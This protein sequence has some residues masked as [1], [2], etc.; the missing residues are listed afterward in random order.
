MMQK[1]IFLQYLWGFAFIYAYIYKYF[2]LVL[3]AQMQQQQPTTPQVSLGKCRACGCMVSSIDSAPAK[4]THLGV[5][6]SHLGWL[7]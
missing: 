5:A 2:Y 4:V 7:K 6:E 1:T 3:A